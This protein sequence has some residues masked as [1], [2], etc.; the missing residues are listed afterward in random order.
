MGCDLSAELAADGTAT[1]GDEDNF[2]LDVCGNFVNVVLDLISSEKVFYL[3][4]SQLGDGDFAVYQ[5]INGRKDLDLSVRLLADANDVSSVF[6]GGTGECNEDLIDVV[7]LNEFWDV[8]PATFD[9]DAVDDAPLFVGVVIDEGQYI[10]PE[11]FRTF[12]LVQDGGTGHTG[13]DDED[14]GELIAV[15]VVVEVGFPGTEDPV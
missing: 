2:V 12:D 5:L 9:A 7:L 15:T 8:F 11:L 13:A 3:D 6:G 14:L 1:T 10:A 4:F